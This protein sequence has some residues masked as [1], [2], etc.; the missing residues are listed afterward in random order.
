[1]KTALPVLLL[2]AFL[3]CFTSAQTYYYINSI[4][5]DPPAPT[6]SDP[7]TI[8]LHGDL[9]ATSSYIISANHT[10]VGNTVYITVDA[11]TTGIGFPVL[12]PQDTTFNIGTL[13]AGTYTINVSGTA[14]WDMAT[15]PEHQFTVI[16]SGLT[17]CDSLEIDV[18]WAP[19]T[20][21]ALVVHVLNHGNGQYNYPNFIFYDAGGDT[22]AKETVN[23]FAI[24]AGG[25][26]WHTLDIQPGVTIPSGT[27]SGGL[28][29]WV[30]F[31]D[32]IACSFP[33]IDD[34]CGPTCDTLVPFMVNTGGALVTANIAWSIISDSTGSVIGSGT[35]DLNPL[36]QQDFDTVECVPP[37]AYTLIVNHPLAV[38]G[39]LQISAQAGGNFL[40]SLPWETFTQDGIP[41]SLSFEWYPGCYDSSNGIKPLPVNGSIQLMMEGEQL[42]L[43][44]SDGKALGDALLLDINGRVLAHYRMPGSSGSLDLSG[45]AHGTY[46]L[47]LRDRAWTRRVVK[48]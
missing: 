8:T 30:L 18:Q 4:S 33:F 7:I 25:Q 22:L 11:G 34:L 38:G 12:T 35:F 36:E 1:M 29:L 28:E 37:G 23:F 16:A 3:P 43:A 17:A 46:L 41:D 45:I 27:F 20:D 42:Q 2:S 47:W 40:A 21:T 9:S 26:S 19:F 48:Y 32:S 31:G 24:I 5:V 10:V 13:P 15:P 44:A 14:I 39:Q 6:T